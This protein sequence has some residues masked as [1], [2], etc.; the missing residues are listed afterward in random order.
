MLQ[1]KRRTSP[2]FE[3]LRLSIRSSR[4]PVTALTNFRRFRPPG[5]LLR[6]GGEL[7]THPAYK[8]LIWSEP[9]PK[10]LQ[11]IPKSTFPYYLDFQRELAWT[12]S[13]LATASQQIAAFVHERE[14]VEALFLSGDL[15]ALNNKLSCLETQFGVCLWL[16]ENR[17]NHAHL[18]GGT[19]AVNQFTSKL[20]S[21][22]KIT[23][24][25]SIIIQWLRFRLAATS[26]TEI[27]R[28]LGEVAPLEYGVHHLFHLLMGRCPPT[29]RRSAGQILS[30]AEQLPAIDRYQILLLSL[31]ALFANSAYSDD[32][33]LF[34]VDTLKVLA[35]NIDDPILIRLLFVLGNNDISSARTQRFAA[36]LEAYSCG[37]YTD[38]AQIV[39]GLGP[40]EL[41][42]E[43][44][45]LRLRSKAFGLVT[46]EEKLPERSLL[47][48]IR[49]DLALI[50][51]FSEEGI[52]AYIG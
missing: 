22:D 1:P 20:L 11:R 42:I 8:S 21:D 13:L 25:V 4:T 47:N 45:N 34:T 7:A 24:F 16:I 31:Q 15:D 52:N 49:S 48:S 27:D 32:D 2:E 36:A 37:R 41:S 9:F 14:N 19:T 12:T 38:V 44:T 40:S 51:I 35:V 3:K 33:R 50:S 46:A 10:T 26:A 17:I 5:E 29:D 39:D 18:V 43:A 28:L 6:L 30:H 23:E